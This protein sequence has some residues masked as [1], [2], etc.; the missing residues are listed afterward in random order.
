MNIQTEIIIKMN[1]REGQ[2]LKKLL[3]CLS[4]NHKR[5]AGLLTDDIES[6]RK[7]YYELPDEDI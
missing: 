5:A 6:M 4:D 7:L 1:Q 2:M 3:G